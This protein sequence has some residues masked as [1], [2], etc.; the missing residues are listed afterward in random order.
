M[1][2]TKI[3]HLVSDYA[4]FLGHAIRVHTPYNKVSNSKSKFKFSY[5]QYGQTLKNNKSNDKPLILVPLKSVITKLS[6]YGFAHLNGCPKSV[7]ILMH[8]NDYDIIQR[9]NNVVRGFMNFYN[10]AHNRADLKQLIYILEYSLAKTLG[11][12]HRLSI[13]QVFAK[14]GKPV[15]VTIQDTKHTNRN[16]LTSN[17]IIFDKPTSLK[18]NYLNV[19]YAR[20]TKYT[21]TKDKGEAYTIKQRTNRGNETN[22]LEAPCKICASIQDIQI[23]HIKQLNNTKDKATLIKVMRMIKSKTINLCRN[24]HNNVHT[25]K[26]DGLNLK[27]IRNRL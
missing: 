13:K 1:D 21:N 22:S 6:D 12:K 15:R 5:K 20:F 9:Y 7:G 10:M 19:K 8:L 14:Y 16:H 3:T 24:C 26:Y 11:K 4:H 27:E 17:T 23:H 18:P 25:G 2:K